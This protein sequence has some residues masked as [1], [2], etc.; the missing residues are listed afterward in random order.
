MEGSSIALCH[1][2][3][4]PSSLFHTL[5]PS[6]PN[7]KLAAYNNKAP[8]DRRRL[9]ATALKKSKDTGIA[10]PNLSYTKDDDDAYF[11]EEEFDVEVLVAEGRKVKA[12]DE[13]TRA[14]PEYA[15]YRIA[16]SA[17][18]LARRISAA[19]TRANSGEWSESSTTILRE[20]TPTFRINRT[21]AS[22]ISSCPV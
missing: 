13:A 8:G 20:I 15:A 4:P 7:N 22:F 19:A 16:Y 11:Y 1:P 2:A 6:R 10:N 9:A 21:T 3:N 14:K 18:A 17:R 12:N 5:S